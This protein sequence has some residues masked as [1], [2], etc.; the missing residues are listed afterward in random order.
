MKKFIVLSIAAVSFV[1]CSHDM[2]NYN[3]SYID[4]SKLQD[5]DPNEVTQ[6]DIQANVASIFGTIDPNQDWNLLSKGSVSITADA[7]LE[8]IVKVQLLT[9]SPFLNP[10]AMVLNQAEA[11][12]GDVVTLTYDAPNA[13]DKLIAACV[14]NS[15]KYYIQVFTPGA[16]SVNFSSSTKARTRATADEVP[17]FT[18]LKLKAPKPSFNAQRAA[19]GESI[20]ITGKV[21][22]EWYNSNWNDQMWD[23]ADGQTFDNGW[24]MDSQ[25][26]MGHLF[27]NINGFEDGEL[28]NVKAIVNDFIYKFV[29]GTSGTKRNNIES[30]R[31]STNFRTSLNY[32]TT[33]GIN[34]IT[35]IP[36]QGYSTDFK[37]NHIY[38]YYYR[39]EDIPSGM[40]E[41]DYIKQLPKFKAIQFERVQGSSDAKN[42]VFFKKQEYLLPFYKN[43]PVE[44]VNE[45][46]PIFP[47]GYKIGFLNRKY[48]NDKEST[49]YTD[50]ESGCTYSDGRLNY[51][52][53]HITHFKMAMDKSLGG[54]IAGGM[55]WT[56]PRIAVF[57]AND[58]TYLTF[59]EGTDCTFS[60]M[61]IEIGSGIK[62][63]E[64][65]YDVDYLSYTMCFEDSPIAD[66]DM[67]DVV[68]KFERLNHTQVKVSLMACGA[69]DELYLRGI[70]GEHLNGTKEIHELFGV[71]NKTFVNTDGKTVK[72]PISDTFSINATQRL[73]DF[74][75]NIYVYDAT[76]K[77]DITL[78][79][80]NE[81]PHAI[82]IPSDFEYPL[83]KK[84]IEDA[85]PL[86]KNWAQNAESDRFWFRKA[87]E[88]FIYKK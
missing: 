9:E 64:E 27:R 59:E 63:V 60:D 68:L 10:D 4:V 72:E 56:D 76:K 71:D 87:Q 83:E 49:A 79:G 7:P 73:S 36:I 66:Y 41:V 11:K 26:N 29:S 1:G 55:T 51:E 58:K 35:L 28:E 54:N 23:L 86:F 34:P 13:Y 18:T 77:R 69:H 53:N 2:G 45:A 16:E 30:I 22:T 42:G 43:A 37:R 32:V 47:E 65:Y 25:K 57:T 38:Y 84:C 8:N 82:V 61:I 5:K 67:N 40:S 3:E 20:T 62:K 31:N 88:E 50:H 6:E 24:Q 48:F 12:F 80:R 15:G 70:D 74:L 39:P 21:H 19:A 85:Y 33:D 75:E 44:G 52:V 81:D 14:S 46:S 17:T 78:A